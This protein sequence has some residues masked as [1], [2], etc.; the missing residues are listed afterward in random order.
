MLKE[1]KV[2]MTRTPSNRSGSEEDFQKVL[3]RRNAKMFEMA[4]LLS[5]AS[6]KGIA[7]MAK[8][9]EKKLY[10]RKDSQ[11][12]GEYYLRHVDHMTTEGLHA[13]SDIARQLAWRDREI[14]ELRVLLAHQIS[15]QLYVD[16]GELQDNSVHPMIDFL[17]D[18]P[19]EIRN[20]LNLRSSK[21][22]ASHSKLKG[23]RDMATD[24]LKK[25]A[26]LQSAMAFN[27]RRISLLQQNLVV[28]KKLA[29]THWEEANPGSAEI[30]AAFR[31][32]KNAYKRL[33]RRDRNQL[34]NLHL[35]QRTLK[36]EARKLQFEER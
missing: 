21:T 17:R 18:P 9:F 33:L 34:Q 31:Q 2:V 1:R 22:Y 30:A 11:E 12:L 13:K 24:Q 4:K 27:A 23:E 25:I 16:D 19:E 32:L 20:K 26:A 6:K 3:E 35:I 5:E 14:Q 8:I 7:G 10:P 36:K 28:S 15:N 29:K